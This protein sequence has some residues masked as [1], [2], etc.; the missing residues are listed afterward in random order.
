MKNALKILAI[1]IFGIFGGIFADQ[2]LWPYFIER[3]LFYQYRLEQSPI[4]VT[5]KKEVIVQENTALT[6]AI[7]KV[8]KVVVG[9]KTTTASQ[10]I[11]EGSGLIVTSDGLIVTLA[12]LIPQGSTPA[13]Y[14]D[15]EK[16]SFKVLK[17]DTKSQFS[18]NKSG[19][20]HFADNKLC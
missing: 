1:F 19:K 10:K 5:E 2:I 8:E 3:P 17:K 20:K 16:L 7:E 14:I 4:Y 11:L 13:L 18:F 12:N 9:I 15:N 6:S